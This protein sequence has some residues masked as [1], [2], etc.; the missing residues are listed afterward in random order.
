[1]N[2]L[3]I[4][5]YAKE[6]TLQLVL[7][8]TVVGTG[9]LISE[10]TKMYQ[11]VLNFEGGVGTCFQRV[12]QTFTAKIINDQS[13]VY[14]TQNFQ[15]L[16][17]ECM[18]EGLI[19]AEDILKK[20]DGATLKK[21]T[22]LASSIH[23][24]HEE[25]LSVGGNAFTGKTKTQ[26]NPSERFEKIEI[27][28][29]DVFEGT[30][31]LKAS[32]NQA[33]DV[34]KLAFTSL[35]GLLCVSVLIELFRQTKRRLVNNRFELE[36]QSELFDYAVL[37]NERTV[38]ILNNSLQ[39]NELHY[40]SKLFNRLMENSN[41]S[42]NKI[43]NLGAI[44]SKA[45]LT[46]TL[47]M[48]IPK[49]SD[50]ITRQKIDLAWEDP[51]M[52]R[53]AEGTISVGNLVNETMELKDRAQQN[54]NQMERNQEPSSSVNLESA[55][56][57]IFDLVSARVF[58]SGIAVELNMDASLNVQFSTEE[59]EQVLFQVFN[60]ALASLEAL[61]DKI[62]RKLT[63]NGIKLGSNIVLDVINTGTLQSKNLID[64]DESNL[65]ESNIGLTICETFMKEHGGKV[66]FDTILNNKSERVG[67]IVK[68]V[69]RSVDASMITSNAKLIDV[70]VGTKKEILNLINQ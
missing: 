65:D 31:A 16:T 25:I 1:M 41:L 68:L 56:E 19:A 7:L 49:E 34:L 20:V 8:G 64:N 22:T 23:W 33:N 40:C 21:F 37:N 24:F 48:I 67:E 26:S 35:M 45:S 44:G 58:K 39:N 5:A 46:K 55:V 54:F 59:L 4:A 69:F 52:V 17:E 3:K 61:D 57:K 47:Q 18:A 63:I 14:L 70:K 6:Y 2:I 32:L 9:F 27:L 42:K 12:N 36:A 38:D 13:S 66:Q 28:K 53:S 11:K 51:S 30:D 50:E 29:D 15:N 43:E 10:N 60:N 62:K